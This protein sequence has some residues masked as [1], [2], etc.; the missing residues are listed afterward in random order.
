MRFRQAPDPARVLP[1]VLD[2]LRN[3]AHRGLIRTRVAEILEVEGPVEGQ[4]LGA[5]VGRAFGISKMRQGRTDDV[6]ALLPNGQIT[7]DRWSKA[8]FVWPEGITPATYDRVL[9]PGEDEGSSR[10][11]GQITHVEI[12]NAARVALAREGEP[13]PLEELIHA[14]KDVLGYKRLGGAMAA[15]LR[16]VLY[17]AVERGAL[18]ERDQMVHLPGET[19]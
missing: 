1:D 4:R 9:I 16:E 14:T 10:S 5:A 15:R 8:R 3:E 2:D 12:V 7:R 18:H 17:D 6:L 13:L 11:I 19:T